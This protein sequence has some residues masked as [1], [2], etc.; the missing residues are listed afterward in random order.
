VGAQT[1]MGGLITNLPLFKLG[2]FVQ[3]TTVHDTDGGVYKT[4]FG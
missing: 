2:I 3:S 4:T 1:D